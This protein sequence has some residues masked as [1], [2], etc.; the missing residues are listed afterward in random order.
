MR[1]CLASVARASAGYDWEAVVVDDGST[2]GT[3]E[4][5]P[6]EKYGEGTNFEADLSQICG[7]SIRTF[8]KC[9]QKFFKKCINFAI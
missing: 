9:S 8:E 2:D 4:V 6:F 7:K 3:A 5:L 1:R